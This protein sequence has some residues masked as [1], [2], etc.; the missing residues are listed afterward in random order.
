MLNRENLHGYQEFL[1]RHIIDNKAC[2]LFFDM[3]AGKTISTLT[4]IDFLLY[5][6]LDVTKVLVVAPKRVASNVWPEEI[7]KWEHVK[8]LSITVIEGTPAKRIELL[9]T[10]SDI[11][12]IGRELFVWLCEHYKYVLPFDMIIFD[13]LSSFKS[14]KAKRFKAAKKVRPRIRR[15]V[16]L[17]GTPAPN[18]LLDLW[19]QLYVLDKGER[20]G[21]FKTRYTSKYF[22]PDPY[23][24]YKLN[25]LPN[26][27]KAIYDKIDD[28]CVS[29]KREDLG[30]KLPELVINKVAVKFDD[31]LVKQ[32]R[33]FEKEKVLML[34]TAMSDDE[35]ITAVNAG[36]VYTKLR[37]F[38]NGA[39]YDE[40]R[41]VHH[42]HDLKL[43][44]LA[45]LLEE[46]QGEPMIIG[47]AF[48][49]DRDRIIELLKKLKIPPR[50][51]KTDK[52]VA[53]WNAGKIQALVVH[54][55]SVGHGLNLQAGGRYL[56]WFGLPTSLEL[57]MQMNARVYRQGQTK[58]VVINII[59]AR[60][61]LDEKIYSALVDKASTQEKLMN[62]VKARILEIKQIYGG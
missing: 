48:Q 54:P 55:A 11:Y 2:G 19:A 7:T 50:E 16:G 9:E 39:L 23:I 61:T 32:Y 44:A 35:P 60:Q 15:V 29:L 31:A 62:A 53:D 47:Y 46:A 22:S 26:A 5:E 27:E 38:A 40:D 3:G 1:A 30:I 6:D 41:K 49:H 8:H 58:M 42:I 12:T 17:T 37:Q 13:E 28:I 25:L 21:K 10:E 24:P 18:G 4:A 51:L 20:L 34:L 57:Y 45:D 59:M 14:S 52:D 43:D 36:V 33:E 56:T